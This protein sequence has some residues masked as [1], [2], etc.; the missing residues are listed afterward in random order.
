MTTK[1]ILDTDPGIDDAAAIAIALNHPAIEV[2]LLTTVAGNVGV[3]KTTLNALKL[4]EY[5]N[6]D[7][8]IARGA[9]KP[10]LRD[11][12]DAVHVHG[13]SGMEGY[14]F[15]KPKRQAI[16]LHAVEA[17]HQVLLAADQPLTL[18][19][20]GALTNVALL[21][22]Q[23]PNIKSKIDRLVVMG[24]GLFAGNT[25]SHAEF[26]IYADPHAA[27]I[28]FDSGL[29]LVMV[30]L[31]VTHKAALKPASLAK[32]AAMGKTGTMLHQ[33]F[34][35]YQDTAAVEGTAMHDVITMFYLLHPE[36]VKTV[37]YHV[38]IVLDGPAVGA[39]VADI[40]AAYHDTTNVAVCMDIDVDFFNQWFV[41]TIAAFA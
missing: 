37:D 29:P 28:V 26:N 6:A 10:L 13:I 33:L 30:G 20:V 25:T 41:E 14:D 5:F 23:Y 32:L 8:P 4:A 9:A 22:S 31:D 34:A 39:T 1:I 7:V 21:L 38:D 16:G 19:A 35:Y 15:P 36:R 24:G 12:E 18:V 40:R 17:M 11:H 2:K 3:D 27:Q